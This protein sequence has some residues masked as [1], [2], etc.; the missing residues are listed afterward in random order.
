VAFLPRGIKQSRRYEILHPGQKP[1]K[2]V[3]NLSTSQ[4]EFEAIRRPNQKIILKHCACALQGSAHG[5]LA[6]EQARGRCSN[7]FLFGDG[8]KRNQ[9][10]Q[11]GLT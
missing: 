6:E 8:C 5:R 2:L 9:Q 11:V 1:L 3:E 7:G 4:C 10:I